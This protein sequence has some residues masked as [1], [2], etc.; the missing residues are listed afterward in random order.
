M[1]RVENARDLHFDAQT[2]VLIIGAGAAGLT[3][4][5]AA[6][7]GTGDVLVLERDAVPAGSTALSSGFVPGAGTQ[8]QGASGDS[9]E[10]FA[11]DI[12]RKA[13]GTQDADLTRLATQ[14]IAGVL[15]WLGRD[16]GLD[17]QVLDS[18][19]YPGHSFHRMH[20]VPEKTGAGLMARMQAAVAASGIPIAT[21]AQ[22]DVLYRDQDRITGVGLIRPDGQRETIGCRA[23]ILACNGYGGN[24]DLVAQ[25]LPQMR[26]ALYFGHEGNQGEAIL[27]GH[28]LGAD[29]R[30]LSGYQGHGS[31]AV[32]HGILI[33]WALMMEGG[34]QVNLSGARFSDETGG[35]SEQAVHVLAQPD[36]RAFNIYDARL[37]A[38]GLG[39]PDYCQ[40][41]EAGAVKSAM[42]PAHLAEKL[43][44]DAGGLE[45]TL[46]GLGQD[47]DPFGR[48]FS[49]T[50]DLTSEYYG[51]E[52]TG[53]LF[54]TQ[55]GLRINERAQ[56]LAGDGRVMPNLFA[57]G[58]AA[59]GVSG[60][61][62][63]GYLSGNGLLTAFAFGAL[64]GHNAARGE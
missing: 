27:W 55:G 3:A 19:L 13:H 58:G 20:A 21:R 4:A 54:H 41:V 56:V 17:W 35:Y 61:D 1:A 59:C 63:S 38:L 34:I 53:A 39:F 64:A 52:V 30:H 23:L 60:P 29:L 43:G 47:E 32:P 2:D 28:Q 9:A 5:L 31:V 57:A 51:I 50:P 33:T 46:E 15:D 16:H 26:D 18:F 36:Q 14:T 40:A 45:A 49:T 6:A 62:V 7:T 37:H 8:A 25:H 42:T 44:I 22:A 10:I 48:D 12:A 11:S 24:P